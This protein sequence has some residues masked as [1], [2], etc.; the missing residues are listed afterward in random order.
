[1]PLMSRRAYARFR[2][3]S[4]VTVQDYISKGQISFECFVNDPRTGKALL[5]SDLADAELKRNL[6]QAQ[7][8]GARN[9]GRMQKEL[10]KAPIVGDDN[11]SQ[12]GGDQSDDSAK[13]SVAPPAKEPT[14]FDLDIER[15]QKSKADTEYHRAKKLALE[16]AVREGSLLDAEKVRK[17]IT[18]LIGETKEKLLNVPAKIAPEL[19]S[20]DDP[21]EIEN[22]LSSE[23]NSV[24]ENLSRLEL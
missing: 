17:L 15:Y 3:V 18:K 9:Q 7:H 16:T 11:G 12:P 21:I 14:A 23:I 22:K 20:M 2:K 10:A 8:M 13:T 24:L 4:H 6:N 1:M 5:D 19:V